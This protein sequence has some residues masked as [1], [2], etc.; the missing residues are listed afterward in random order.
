MAVHSAC[1]TGNVPEYANEHQTSQ[2]RKRVLMSSLEQLD[3]S[4]GL[5]IKACTLL[6]V[7]LPTTPDAN[8]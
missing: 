8:G 6:A 7:P 5:I 2:V 1:P 4:R 3:S